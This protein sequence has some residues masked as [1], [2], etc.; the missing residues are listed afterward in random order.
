[1]PKA[2][3][4]E[5]PRRRFEPVPIYWD[6]EEGAE[7]AGMLIKHILPTRGLTL[8]VGQSGFYKTFIVLDLQMACILGTEFMGQPVMRQGGALLLVA[9]GADTIARRWRALKKA[10]AKSYFE[11]LGQDMPALPFG[12]VQAVPHLQSQDAFERLVAICEQFRAELRERSQFD[13]VSI[14]IDTLMAASLFKKESESGEPSAVLYM[15]E[16]LALQVNANVLAVDHMGKDQE[17]GARGTSGKLAPVY[18]ELSIFGTKDAK[19]GVISGTHL[20]LTKHR[21]GMAGLKAA[22]HPIEIKLGVDEQ[23]ETI[24]DMVLQWDGGVVTKRAA[25]NKR[26]TTLMEAFADVLLTHGKKFQAEPDW[27]E[28][29]AVPMD[30]LREKFAVRYPADGSDPKTLLSTAHRKFRDAMRD[31]VAAHVIATYTSETIGS[32]A[33]LVKED[34]NGQQRTASSMSAR[35]EGD[36][37]PVH[38]SRKWTGVQ[39]S[40]GGAD[41]DREL[42]F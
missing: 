33:W 9:E 36:G 17:K 19:S 13:L 5:Q 26:H 1:M 37:Q 24:S 41:D 15:L 11:H 32:F 31:A 28:V 35:S 23:G 6:E 3:G 18:S 27:P 20:V 7:P 40:D 12:R 42:E 22:F 21:T 8:L 34:S 2:N 4:R 30:V 38:F 39:P 10:K 14:A 29:M 25:N 16:K